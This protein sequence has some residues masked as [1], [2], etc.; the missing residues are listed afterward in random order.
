MPALCSPT[1]G[2]R[3]GAVSACGFSCFPARRGFRRAGPVLHGPALPFPVR[4]PRLGP[5]RVPAGPCPAGSC[6]RPGPTRP[7]PPAPGSGPRRFRPKP[8]DAGR[9]PRGSVPPGPQLVD[10]DR[11]RQ[12]QRIPT[13]ARTFGRP[14]TK[15]GKWEPA[16]RQPC[17]R[18]VAGPRAPGGPRSSGLGGVCVEGCGCSGLTQRFAARPPQI[19]FLVLR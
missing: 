5:A 7:G 13:R 19:C 9:G 16:R 18:G 11:S 12:P 8:G 14:V 2:G 10:P 1:S 6:F 17:A 15:S 4:G 3:C